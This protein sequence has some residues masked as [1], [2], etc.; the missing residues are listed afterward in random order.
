MKNT[1][2]IIITYNSSEFIEE[3]LSSVQK[4][5]GFNQAQII[6]WDNASSDKTVNI[7]ES[8]FPKVKLFKSNQNLGFGAAINQVVQKIDTEY[9][10]L[11]NPDT[12]VEKNW[13]NG[14]L[15]TFDKEKKV[16]AVNSKTK[17]VIDGKKYIQNAGSHLFHDGHGRDRGAVISSDH[18]QSYEEDNEF[19]NQL[20]EVDAFSGVSV[21]IPRKLFI[22]LGGFDD[23]MFMYYEDT[24]LSIRMKKKGYKVFYQPKSELSHLHSASSEEWSKF[25]VYQTELNRLLLVLKHFPLKTVFIEL[26]KYK[27]ST[28]YQLLKLKK[29]FF[30]RLKVLTTLTT[31]LPYLLSYRSQNQ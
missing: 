6:V 11:L 17:I 16:G 14:L 7:I 4:V 23:H 31:K 25:F 3:C 5:N 22:S 12:Q 21:M 29:R 26:F 20:T 27:L 13:L 1:S 10:V 19:Y 9:I 24:D 28:I 15:E 8:K 18:Q 30:T 2:I